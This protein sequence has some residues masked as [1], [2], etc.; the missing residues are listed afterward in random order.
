MHKIYSK[1]FPQIYS[2]FNLTHLRYILIISKS[3]S[4]YIVYKWPCAKC[5]YR[6]AKWDSNRYQ[7]K[8]NGCSTYLIHRSL[9]HFRNECVI[10]N[11]TNSFNKLLKGIITKE[12][13]RYMN[14]RMKLFCWNS[15]CNWSEALATHAMISCLI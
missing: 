3:F 5:R 6:W 11:Y 9:V 14:F 13:H 4:S 15:K 7:I 12:S 2:Q 10:I 1:C 8:N